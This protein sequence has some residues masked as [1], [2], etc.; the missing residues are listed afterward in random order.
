MLTVSFSFQVLI[1]LSPGANT[2][3]TD[4]KLENEARSSRIVLAPTVMTSSTRAGDLYVASPLLFPAATTT[5]TPLLTSCGQ[6]R[7]PYVS[8]Y[9]FLHARARLR[10]QRTFRAAS[11]IAEFAFPPR[12]MEAT[13]GL[14]LRFASFIAYC[15][16][17]ILEY[18]SEEYTEEA[19]RGHIHVCSGPRPL[20]A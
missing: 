8:S 12:D 1:T 20:I 7:T 16:P 11:S 6:Y 10:D 14:P 18:E 9:S 3:T 19:N 5:W 15:M 2:S 13:L 17:L 4:P